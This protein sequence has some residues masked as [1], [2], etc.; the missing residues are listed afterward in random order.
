MRKLLLF[1]A[2][3]CVSIGTWAG[4]VNDANTSWNS[5]GYSGIIEAYDLQP[6]ELAGY[7]ND[8][9]CA[10]Y[11]KLTVTESSNTK[12][13]ALKI[14]NS[15]LNKADL[16]ALA[17][18]GV[19]IT[20]LDLDDVTLDSDA[21]ISD[22]TSSTAKWISLPD[23]IT[24]LNANS[25]PNCTALEAACALPTSTSIVAYVK[26]AGSL[27]H[28][29]RLI[30]A[31]SDAQKLQ[32]V[33][34][35]KLVGN[36]EPNDFMNGAYSDGNAEEDNPDDAG[37][38]DKTWAQ[39]YAAFYANYQTNPAI[40]KIDFSEATFSDPAYLRAVTHYTND[41]EAVV[42]PTSQNVIPHDCFNLCTKLGNLEIPENYISIGHDAFHQCSSMTRI[43]IG[44]KI[45]SV[46]HHAFTLCNALN[47][48]EFEK[49]ISDLDF[50]AYS[51]AGIPGLKHVVLPEGVRNLGEYMFQQCE[52]LASIRLPSTL[53]NIEGHC[54]AGC[55]DL[56][57]ITI[58]ENVKTIG[59]EA[60]GNS[61]LRDIYVMAN[62]VDQLP[63]IYPFTNDPTRQDYSGSTFGRNSLV[64]N[65]A[66]VYGNVSTNTTE[67]INQLWHEAGNI[68]T[69]LHYRPE[70]KDFI[71][72]N[73]WYPGTDSQNEG[74]PA[75]QQYLSD[76]Y[77]YVDSEGEHWPKQNNGAYRGD[78]SRVLE[79][80]LITM[81]GQQT[82]TENATREAWR[83]F[84]LK[85]G[86]AEPGKTVYEKE[87]TDVWYTMCFPWHLNDEQ[88]EEAFN[89][90]YNICEFSGAEIV[91]SEREGVTVN[92]MILHFNEIATEKTI[93]GEGYLA[94]AG[95]PY[96]IHPNIGVDPTSADGKVKCYFT[97][98]KT[99]EGQ[100][101]ENVTKTLDG[102]S[103]SM[104][105]VGTFEDTALPQ[106]SYFL[107]TKSGEY[108]PK[109]WRRGSVDTAKR[110]KQYTAIVKPDAE[111]WSY[112]SNNVLTTPNTQGAKLA[113]FLIDEYVGEDS[114]A[115][116][117][118]EI[119]NEAK[120]KNLPVEYMN[121]IYNINGQVISNDSK[122][123][124]NLP[125]G[126][127]IV[128]G[129]KYFV[130]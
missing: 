25:L 81:D 124:Q 24:E 34:D 126:L 20:Y 127:Y 54:F 58:P 57:Q 4:T 117:I 74:S 92:N 68:A 63:L 14:S 119:L 2:M 27:Y 128:N 101:P 38:L 11:A 60:F 17:K 1:F 39:D 121:V 113:E 105:F 75:E 103:G 115:T 36:I 15:T 22:I 90:E 109:F 70:L 42:L 100:E 59:R 65:N 98:I 99:I 112:I 35:L 91:Q 12:I 122:D 48:V 85:F 110:W 52:N 82:G 18:I 32:R 67:E 40:K 29:T 88:L 93:D 86:D 37:V 102:G 71:D 80:G 8:P 9:T 56:V 13:D 46:G 95:H 73:P 41:L 77:V 49:G 55:K 10:E 123:L 83:Q 130:K 64:N 16:E 31:N 72:Y 7:L 5:V 125:K 84:M 50:E 26:E 47:T 66:D 94:V 120:E 89:A 30:P 76:T 87:Y 33:T 114:E 118:E 23:G 106:N 116:D 51:F 19:N 6:G 28:A 69:F 79:S 45:K 44:K 43:K 129:K 78:F 3:L 104:S 111:A 108:Y 107:G 62:S 53:Q 61:G 96:M 21:S 97:G